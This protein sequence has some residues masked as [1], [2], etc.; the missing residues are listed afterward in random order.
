MNYFLSSCNIGLIEDSLASQN[1]WNKITKEFRSAKFIQQYE[2]MKNTMKGDW[3]WKA[4]NCFAIIIVD[5]Q[6]IEIKNNFTNFDKYWVFWEIHKIKRHKSVT[7]LRR[8]EYQT[9]NLFCFQWIQ[10]LY[11]MMI[12]SCCSWLQDIG[13]R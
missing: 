10:I 13:F 3:R 4:M 1:Y 12:T 2:E 11:W 7:C 9:N 6:D 5:Y 8:G